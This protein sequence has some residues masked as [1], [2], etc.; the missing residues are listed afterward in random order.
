[1][2]NTGEKKKIIVIED[3]E[4]M[5]NSCEKIL[6]RA[7]FEVHP[8]KD[9]IQG[10]KGVEEVKPDLIVV[11]L[12]MPGMS[13]MEVIRRVHE[14]NPDIILIVIT[15]YA[16]VA[17]AVEAI[18]A[19]AYDYLPKP[20]LPDEL[21]V[22]VNRGLE[23]RKLLFESRRLEMERELLKR[24]FISMVAHQLRSPLVAIRQYLEVLMHLGDIPESSTRWNKWLERCIKRTN[25]LLDL[26]RDWL[27]LSKVESETFAEKTEKVD[28]KPI[29]MNIFETYEKMA[30]DNS[31]SLEAN[32][33]DEISC[34]LGDKNSLNVIFDN[35]ITNAIKY[36]KPHGRVT[37]TADMNSDKIIVS[38][39]DTGIGIPEEYK[40]RLFEDFF[41]VK[42]RAEEYIQ[43]TGLG[44]SICKRII[45]KMGGTI[46]VE[47]EVNLGSTFRVSLPRYYEPE[48]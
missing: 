20:F 43:G 35:L 28:I 39:K 6:V 3:D 4:V 1:M 12:K 22:I 14:F 38:V 23:H 16:T 2:T 21:R 9:G 40:K 48:K 8:F 19:G 36:N 45:S 46:E 42:G 31:I 37:I 13:G 30:Q 41:R 7:G 44:L 27:T 29:I 34:V 10:L 5:L 25:E 15:G 24:R 17:S 47:S 11:D 26:V 33:P 18:K 32:I